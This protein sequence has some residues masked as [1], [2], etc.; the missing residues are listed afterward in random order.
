MNALALALQDLRQRHTFAPDD[1]SDQLS[2]E[3]A[4]CRPELPSNPLDP[5]P[6]DFG[7]HT[8]V[9]TYDVPPLHRRR[10]V[11]DLRLDDATGTLLGYCVRPKPLS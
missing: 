4:D 3:F 2:F 5:V 7:E 9:V 6:A 1:D 8:T 10:Y 11:L